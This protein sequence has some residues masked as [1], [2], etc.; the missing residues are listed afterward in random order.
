M[1]SFP[2]ENK[3]WSNMYFKSK[4]PAKCINENLHF[5]SS[6]ITIYI[7][8]LNTSMKCLEEAPLFSFN[9]KK[10]IIVFSNENTIWLKLVLMVLNYYFLQICIWNVLKSLMFHSF[11]H[12]ED[13]CL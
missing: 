11:K 10:N 7:D 8:Q 13:I 4:A 6:Q 5:F 1:G 2:M 12:V 3:N 9:K